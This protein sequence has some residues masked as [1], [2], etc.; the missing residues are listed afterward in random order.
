MLCQGA[1]RAL[2]RTRALAGRSSSHGLAQGVAKK[3][4]CAVQLLGLRVLTAAR[5]VDAHVGLI[6]DDPGVVAGRDP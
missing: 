5:E 6:A 1:T 4:G 3:C 2:S